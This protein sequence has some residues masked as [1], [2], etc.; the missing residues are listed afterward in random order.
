M[1][2]FLASSFTLSVGAVHFAAAMP[3]LPLGNRQLAKVRNHPVEDEL[4]PHVQFNDKD[5]RTRIVT[6][7]VNRDL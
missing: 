7:L 3:F 4:H 6:Q 5:S 1:R 2:N